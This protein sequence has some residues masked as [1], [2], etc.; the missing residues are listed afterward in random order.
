[1][2]RLRENS[3]PR[4]L[5]TGFRAASEPARA[6]SGPSDVRPAA[7]LVGVHES[8][9][10]ILARTRDSGSADRGSTGHRRAVLDSGPLYLHTVLSAASIAGRK[11]RIVIESLFQMEKSVKDFG[12]L[13]IG[14]REFLAIL[15]LLAVATVA[16]TIVLVIS[17][18]E[19]L[20]R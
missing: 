2:T 7:R 3:T 14:V 6:W 13:I 20:E 10:E 5:A 9:E 4:H 1:M 16:T 17:R 12:R 18:K 15:K 11:S 8:G 19:I